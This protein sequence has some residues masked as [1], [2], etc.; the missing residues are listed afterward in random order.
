MVIYINLKKNILKLKNIINYY[1]IKLYGE[2]QN[3][4]IIQQKIKK[5]ENNSEKKVDIKKRIRTNP[6]YKKE[7]GEKNKRTN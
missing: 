1:S 2:E 3:K 5:N 7:F 6:N 4:N